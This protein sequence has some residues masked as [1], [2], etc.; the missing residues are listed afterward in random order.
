MQRISAIGKGII[1]RGSLRW[2]A[3]GTRFHESRLVGSVL[4]RDI[5]IIKPQDTFALVGSKKQ[6]RANSTLAQEEEKDQDVYQPVSF[7]EY[8]KIDQKTLKAL[9]AEFG[10]ENATKV[11]NKIIER[12]PINGD[13]MIKAKTGT[14]K[15]LAFLIAG[16]EK[17]VQEY[18]EKKVDGRGKK[19]E[20]IG[21]MVVSPTRELAFQIGEEAR[22]LTKFHGFDVSMFVGG[23][24]VVRQLR[25]YR[26]KN[27]DIVVGTP[28]R[29]L[30][31]WENSNLFRESADQTKIL[32]FDEADMLLDM[33]FQQEVDKIIR[34]SPKDRQ[35]YLVSA[36]MSTKI[37]NVATE[38]FG[39]KD[40][41][42]LDCVEKGE[43][44]VLQNIKQSYVSVGWD[45]HYL[46]MYSLINSHIKKMK[47]ELKR[48]AKIIVFLPT[49]KSVQIYYEVLNTL[50]GTG[51]HD[52]RRGARGG[53]G[54]RYGDNSDGV[55]VYCLHGKKDQ[56]T[57]SN[58][59]KRFR[60]HGTNNTD[61]AILVTSDVS[62][63][64]VDY[65]GTSFVIQVGVPGSV[66]QYIHRIGRTGRA[67]KQGEG[68]ILLSE[69]DQVFLDTVEK[70]QKV[71]IPHN[72]DLDREMLSALSNAYN[73]VVAKEKKDD[74]DQADHE[75]PVLTEIELNEREKYVKEVQKFKSKFDRVNIDDESADQMYTS[76]LG[77]YTSTDIMSKINP[78]LLLTHLAK[79]LL[80]FG[81]VDT[82]PLPRALR[83]TFDSIITKKNNAMRR[84]N[85]TNYNRRGGGGFNMGFKSNYNR[86]DSF[87]G[88][89]SHKNFRGKNFRDENNA[90]FGESYKFRDNNA[91]NQ[92]GGGY[93]SNDRNDRH[94][95]GY[96]SGYSRNDDDNLY[97]RK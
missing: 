5:Q 41:E 17:L 68:V 14:G 18:Q 25:E 81:I 39:K 93:R 20:K 67:G 23:E 76:F 95:G 43:G 57:R 3:T 59:S 15:T 28:G 89:N 9:K 42:I 10:Y 4:F 48:G 83:E 27:H 38:A 22:R 97:S 50:L 65:P 72:E 79:S 11:Q 46:A 8:G 52:D 49:T 7:K 71:K 96:N 58:I 90:G 51:R 34:L 36:T 40:F 56:V 63:R 94:K 80:P 70:E 64:G 85:S 47:D 73:D 24:P 78:S 19:R 16:I 91:S 53:R 21:I 1:R 62:A 44:N 37:R 54:G 92:R 55:F 77:F 74:V 6:F 33:G 75:E 69:A 32:I 35:T 88:K 13:L 2:N 82:P 31:V 12:M 45:K 87:A 30:D 84:Q 61:S 29:L 26:Y 86:N 60:A 66:E